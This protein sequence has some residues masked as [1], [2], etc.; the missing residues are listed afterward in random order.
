MT[1]RSLFAIGALALAAGPAGAWR[2]AAQTIAEGERPVVVGSKP[3]AESYI[4]AEMFAQLLEARGYRV[5]RRAGLGATEISFRA[6]RAGAIECLPGIHGDRPRR[7]PGRTPNVGPAS[8]LQTG[9][10]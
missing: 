3:F 10:R 1:A 7:D 9:R 6:L 8:R 5:Q 2:A 4:L